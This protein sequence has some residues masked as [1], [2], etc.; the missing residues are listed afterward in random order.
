M[1]FL[2]YIIWS[3]SFYSIQYEIFVVVNV[4]DISLCL[5]TN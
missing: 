1:N 4:L 2:I 3:N 5:K